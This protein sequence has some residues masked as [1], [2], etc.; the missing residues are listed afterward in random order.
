[1]AQP[2][3]VFPPFVGNQGFPTDPNDITIREGQTVTVATPTQVVTVATQD[4]VVTLQ[5]G[6]TVS[7][8]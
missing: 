7:V 8:P 1:M 2:I 3:S 5:S 4:I 6:P